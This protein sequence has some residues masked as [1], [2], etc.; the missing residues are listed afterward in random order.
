VVVQ[1]SQG[2]AKSL[3]LYMRIVFVHNYYRQ[4]GG[5]DAVF[6]AESTLLEQYGHEVIRYTVSNEEVALYSGIAL[7]GSTLW[8][9]AQYRNIRRLVH[10]QHPDIV[11]VHNTVP[12]ISPSIYYA[13]EAE[14]VPLVQMLHNYRPFCL[15][16]VLYRD[17]H[18][19]EDCIGRYPTSGV[20]HKCYRGSLAASTGVLALYAI[21][22]KMLHTYQNH[23]SLS[24]TSTQ[25]AKELFVRMGLDG[26]KIIVK[27]NFVNVAGTR[28]NDPSLNYM[29]KRPIFVG[30][31]D[32][33]K[34]I[35]TLLSAIEKVNVPL[36]LIGDG[37]LR[38]Q[39]ERWL[40][41]RPGLNV[42]ITGW[43]DASKL[44]EHFGSASMLILPSE[45]YESFGNVIV[46]AFSYGIPVITTNFGA[47]SELVQDGKNGFLFPLGDSSALSQIIKKL[48][49]RPELCQMLGKNARIE[50]EQKYTPE[51][52]CEM[53]MSIYSQAIEGGK[54]S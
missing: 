1:T 40:R 12:L 22:Y 53:L 16:G 35:W 9:H 5:E 33:R 8:N 19:C 38:T 10:N 6:N 44:S 15:N 20:I 39:V 50:Y 49:E 42:E 18:I 17:G 27:P 37:E 21:H 52:N 54:K 14:G 30:R 48:S 45:F 7:A 36:V 41:E 3:G 26:E 2:R 47:Q 13:A 28:R 32:D 51:R 4:S 31:L 23:I 11:H 46:E 29:K 43:L 34:G 24:I 25:F